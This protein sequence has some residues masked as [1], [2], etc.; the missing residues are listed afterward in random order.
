MIGRYTISLEKEKAE[1]V[2]TALSKVNIPL[3]GYLATVVIALYA[4][5][6]GKGAA[7]DL[8]SADILAAL[9][10]IIGR[11]EMEP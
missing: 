8:S 9:H 2:K 11:I 3:S 5:L 10:D 4:K 6:E 7:E 1:Y